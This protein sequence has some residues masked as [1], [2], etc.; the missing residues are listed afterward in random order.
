MLPGLRFLCAAVVLSMSLLVFGFGATALLRSARQDAA[1]LPALRAPPETVFAQPEAQPRLAMLRVEPPADNDTPAAA[2]VP[3]AAPIDAAPVVAT[4]SDSDRT[5]TPEKPAALSP[6]QPAVVEAPQQPQ[7]LPQ[8][9]PETVKSDAP[10]VEVAQP[11]IRPAVEAPVPAPVIEAAPVVMAAATPAASAEPAPVAAQPSPAEPSP[12][13]ATIAVLGGPAVTVTPVAAAKPVI[14][15]PKPKEKKTVR[16]R[17]V[18]RKRVAERSAPAPVRQA[19]QPAD[20][21]AQF[22]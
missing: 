4:L 9:V 1:S 6:P 21:F 12:V 14:V 16:K 18:K 5:A 3:A 19:P 13:P 20:P 17:T 11:D 10:P 15:A 2:V 8:I 7:A 22:R